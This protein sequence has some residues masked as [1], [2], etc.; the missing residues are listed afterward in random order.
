MGNC[1]GSEEKP[2]EYSRLDDGHNRGGQA[3]GSAATG[4]G[5]QAPPE[6]PSGFDRSRPAP[7]S[8]ADA[9]P[10]RTE[11]S[12]AEPPKAEPSKAAGAPRETNNTTPPAT[13]PAN[14]ALHTP[15]A[16]AAAPPALHHPDHPHKHAGSS[17][18]FPAK[19]AVLVDLGDSSEPSTPVAAAPETAAVPPVVEA[20]NPANQADGKEVAAAAEAPE[21]SQPEPS[22]QLPREAFPS[23]ASSDSND[24]EEEPEPSAAAAVNA[25]AKG[26]G[27]KKNKKNK[28][29]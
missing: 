14:P 4:S 27:K 5:Y 8:K 15:P 2:G 19:E 6:F 3:G 13:M 17:V 11:P 25:P 18:H 23:A 12:K 7:S 29:K 22:A 21:A 9:S 26:K 20:A 10:A 24:D 1:C 16:V 28:K